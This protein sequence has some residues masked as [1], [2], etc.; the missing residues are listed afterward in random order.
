MFRKPGSVEGESKVKRRKI[1]TTGEYW[2]STGLHRGTV[3]LF[4]KPG[5]VG[6]ESKVKRRKILT[7]GD[8]EVHRGLAGG[9]PELV[10]D[11]RHHE[12]EIEAE[13]PE[14]E[15]FSTLEVAAGDGILFGFD[16]LA[17]FEGGENPGLVGVRE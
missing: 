7:T 6:G 2:G 1:F 12:E 16:E 5:L 4:R 10:S 9:D 3:A 11:N 8:T 14:N 13:R 17:G 15:E